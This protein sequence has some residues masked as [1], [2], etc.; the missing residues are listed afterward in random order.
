[1]EAVRT[2]S[3]TFLYLFAVRPQRLRSHVIIEGRDLLGLLISSSA[4]RHPPV[5]LRL[6]NETLW[7]GRL[8][9]TVWSSTHTR[10]RRVPRI[11]THTLSHT[12][13]THIHTH[14]LS[15]AHTD[16][17]SHT[18]THITRTRT[19][20]PI[21]IRSPLWLFVLCYVWFTGL[22]RGAVVCK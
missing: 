9:T 13:M 8:L 2:I 22:E 17:L 5:N 19:N 11:Y 6:K 7:P 4:P 10:A 18:H 15:H 12:H 16:S 21:Q 1:M 20:T 3:K 14:S